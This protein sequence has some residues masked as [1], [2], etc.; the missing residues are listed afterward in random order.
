MKKQMKLYFDGEEI[1]PMNQ[2]PFK[3]FTIRKL[4]NN[5][6]YEIRKFFIILKV[7]RTKK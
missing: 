2:E 4:L 7:N 6:R 1:K 5:I 3:R